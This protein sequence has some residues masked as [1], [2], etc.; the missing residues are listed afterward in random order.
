MPEITDLLMLKRLIYGLLFLLLISSGAAA[1]NWEV[2]GFAGSSG[3]MGDFNQ[4][5][6]F[7]FTDLSLGAFVKKNF[8]GYFSAKLGYTYARIQGAD[9]LSSNQQLRNRNLSFFT[10]INEVS[11][12]G[13]L[14]FFNYLPGISMK[15]WSPFIFAG[16]ALVNYKPKTDYQG[17]TYSLRPL[18]TEG[19]EKEYAH[20]TLSIPY[21][22]GV[23]VNF[24]R[25]WNIAL[26][27]G[28][29]TAFTDYLDDVSTVYANKA[30]LSN[31]Y[32]GV[33]A[34]RSGEK[35]GYYI[36]STGSQ[37]GDLRPRDT[38]MITGFSISYTFLS[39]KCPVVQR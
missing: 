27:L 9:S 2:G 6:P 18:K 4:N 36:G 10:P 23:K 30:R 16:V 14:N 25:S 31:A 26:E 1:Q 34:D 28:Y 24:Y 11:L 3:Y 8:N 7:K 33:L 17:D 35:N 12:N 38:Y 19:Q 29:R 20:N 15:R 22:V 39:E 37:R 21:G 13:E 32:S 5:N